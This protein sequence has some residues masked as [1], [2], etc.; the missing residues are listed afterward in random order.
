[1]SIFPV[2]KREI[3][4]PRN[5][6]GLDPQLRDTA[7]LL[8]RLIA[9]SLPFPTTGAPFQIRKRID[10]RSCPGRSTSWRHCRFYSLVL[11]CQ[12]R[13]PCML[14]SSE[15]KVEA[16]HRQL[17]GHFIAARLFE[18]ELAD[19]SFTITSL[20]GRVSPRLRKSLG[21]VRGRGASVLIIERNCGFE[22]GLASS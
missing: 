11:Q 14:R 4:V 18:M 21:R 19:P 1:M 16:P 15:T 8:I 13:L 9:W 3:K 7:I 2:P 22:D 20:R 10:R 12:F 6:L 5:H 17:A